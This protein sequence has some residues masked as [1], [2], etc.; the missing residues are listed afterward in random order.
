MKAGNR[1]WRSSDSPRGSARR[2]PDPSEMRDRAQ[3]RAGLLPG[4]GA[5]RRVRRERLP[6]G[7]ARPAQSLKDQKT[8]AAARIIKR[9]AKASDQATAKLAAKVTTADAYD[10]AHTV[11][12]AEKFSKATVVLRFEGSAVLADGPL[13]TEAHLPERLRQVVV[14]DPGL[15][16]L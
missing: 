5:A 7:P 8:S 2:P 6:A 3:R 9:L 14:D 1:R 13:I 12:V 15:D 4:R 11:I 16:R 10:A